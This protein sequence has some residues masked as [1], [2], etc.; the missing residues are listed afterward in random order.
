MLFKQISLTAIEKFCLF[1]SITALKKRPKFYAQMKAL[2]PKG[3]LF[4]F[5][6]ISSK[7]SVIILIFFL[8]LEL[9]INMVV[10]ILFT[11]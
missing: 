9:V 10:I 1:P 11:F 5:E 7:G 4:K 6:S 2:C 8:V 3:M